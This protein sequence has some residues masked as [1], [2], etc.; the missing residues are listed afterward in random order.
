M[1]S[2]RVRE[3]HGPGREPASRLV[4]KVVLMTGQLGIGGTEKQIVL[5]SR[6]LRERGIDT[7]V[8]ILWD[9]GR[10]EERNEAA[11]WEAGVQIA[12]IGLGGFRQINAALRNFAGLGSMVLRLRWERPN[13]V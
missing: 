12:H 3:N 2:K 11:L 1:A 5:L 13:I 10:N 7:S 9:V 6:G 4:G 8:W